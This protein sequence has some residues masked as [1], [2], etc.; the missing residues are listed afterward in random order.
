MIAGLFGTVIDP[1]IHLYTVFHNDK[2]SSENPNN[3]DLMM[4]TLSDEPPA[5]IEWK[6]DSCVSVK[7]HGW[8]PHWEKM[9]FQH[10]K[11]HLQKCNTN[12]I[13]E[14]CYD[15]EKKCLNP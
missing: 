2:L 9:S 8:L 14:G 4:R 15:L 11:I 6:S 10:H 3:T 1:H 12:G 13:P 5:E 7:K